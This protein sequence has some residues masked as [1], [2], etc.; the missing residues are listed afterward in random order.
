MAAVCAGKVK[1]AATAAASCCAMYC[2]WMKHA[3]AASATELA[4]ARDVSCSRRAGSTGSIARCKR[5]T[6]H[7]THDPDA[8]TAGRVRG[9]PASAGS[10]WRPPAPR[11]ARRPPPAARR[12]G[13]QSW[14]GRLVLQLGW[15]EDVAAPC[16]SS[17]ARAAPAASPPRQSAAPP[18]RPRW[19]A[20]RRLRAGVSDE[21]VTQR[22][23][24]DAKQSVPRSS[25][26][27]A[28]ASYST[29]RGAPRSAGSASGPAPRRRPAH[30]SGVRRSSRRVQ[31]PP[32]RGPA[33]L[34]PRDALRCRAAAPRAG[35]QLLPR[36][37]APKR[38]GH[39]V[40][41]AA[42]TGA[43]AG[44]AA[45][46]SPRPA[47]CGAKPR[48]RQQQLRN[49]ER[50]SQQPEARPGEQHEKAALLVIGAAGSAA[51]HVPGQAPP[52]P[53]GSGTGASGEPWCL[54]SG[55]VE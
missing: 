1:P 13:G 23:V 11:S 40:A 47:A 50:R 32:E 43:A 7:A 45:C 31:R 8:R 48:A 20:A 28:S 29:G 4:S 51:T 25:V 12:A 3:A 22:H 46:C 18:A 24:L 2:R 36:G 44:V 6:R 54:R 33:L 49:T 27:A 26:A 38:A 16:T 14:W 34:A 42:R 5:R 52:E 21:E 35:V 53:P 15:M 41:A 9:L 37:A 10:A 19:P 17:H 55:R 30:R 39:A